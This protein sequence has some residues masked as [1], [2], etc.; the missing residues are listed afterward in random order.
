LDDSTHQAP[1]I[2]GGVDFSGGDLPMRGRPAGG[3]QAPSIGSIYSINPVCAARPRSTF[4]SARAAPRGLNRP[5][6]K[7]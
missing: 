5:G 4:R 1:S 7:F 3:L 2:M 6:K